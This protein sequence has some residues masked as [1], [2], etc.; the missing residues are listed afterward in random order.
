[1]QL[2]YP[3]YKKMM[4]NEFTEAN[5]EIEEAYSLYWDTI[6]QLDMASCELVGQVTDLP[7]KHQCDLIELANT[8]RFAR[9]KFQENIN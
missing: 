1:M 6:G 5:K 3:D 4:F 7:S 9:L 8:I 2:G